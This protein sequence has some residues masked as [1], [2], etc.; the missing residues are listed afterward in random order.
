ML[1]PV[2]VVVKL[3]LLARTKALVEEGKLFKTLTALNAVADAFVNVM[4]NRELP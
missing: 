1:P 4:V 2:Q 3:G